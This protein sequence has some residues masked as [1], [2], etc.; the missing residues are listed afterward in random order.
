[1][2]IFDEASEG[3]SKK[4]NSAAPDE[5]LGQVELELGT[6]KGEGGEDAVF[7]MR[8]FRLGAGHQA[9]PLAPTAAPQTGAVPCSARALGSRWRA[10]PDSHVR[11]CSNLRRAA[12]KV[13]RVKGYASLRVEEESESASLW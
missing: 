7:G 3:G 5:F 10:R 9:R 2:E 6:E 13:W 8:S 12:A 11:I 1:M 4:K